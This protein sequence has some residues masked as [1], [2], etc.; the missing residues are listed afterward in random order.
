MPSWQSLGPG[1]GTGHGSHLPW[2]SARAL[3]ALNNADFDT[4]ELGIFR[5]RE[6]AKKGKGSGQKG[7]RPAALFGVFGAANGCLLSR[8]GDADISRAPAP[9]PLGVPFSWEGLQPPT[10]RVTLGELL[11]LRAPQPLRLSH[12]KAE[13]AHLLRMLRGEKKAVCALLLFP[14]TSSQPYELAPL[15]PLFVKWETKVQRAQ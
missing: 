15:S 2:E 3:E 6:G 1:A 13:R 4:N 9:P 8:R 11:L 7:R 5:H 14:R 10:T 12:G